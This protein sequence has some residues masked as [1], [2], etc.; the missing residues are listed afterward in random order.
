MEK[1]GH[2]VLRQDRAPQKCYGAWFL[3]IEAEQ[4]ASA[5]FDPGTRAWDAF[6]HVYWHA[7]MVRKGYGFRW[8]QGL[9]RAY[10][11]YSDNEDG[12][13]D[14]V[15]NR[16]GAEIGQMWKEGKRRRGDYYDMDNEVETFVKS[17]R[18]NTANQLSKL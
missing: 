5:K 17:G 8:S 14:L 15:N 18:A 13:G 10:E 2:L 16:S 4:I 6:K 7:L 1:I 12:P 9:G 3:G 11:G